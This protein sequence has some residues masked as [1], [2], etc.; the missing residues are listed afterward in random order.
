[1][2]KVIASVKGYFGGAIREP[3]ASFDVPD[4]LWSDEK[5]R[6]SWA[7]A[8]PGHKVAGKTLEA[9]ASAAPAS[10]AA[11]TVPADWA[12][13][14]AP[15]RKALARSI[16]GQAAPN[17]AEADKVISAYIAS[18]A[19]APFGD[20][21]APTVAAG[22]GIQAALGGVHPDWVVPTPVE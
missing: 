1:M 4:E 14:S 3:G 12:S 16:S 5:R 6:P 20:A 18:V 2:V 7:V 11:V 21:P 8:D 10:D 13:R 19:P 15:E 22:N 17:V 9:V